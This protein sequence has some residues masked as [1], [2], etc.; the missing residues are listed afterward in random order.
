[1]P[2]VDAV[3]LRTCNDTVPSIALDDRANLAD[4]MQMLHSDAH[5]PLDLEA[6]PAAG[7]AYAILVRLRIPWRPGIRTLADRTLPAGLYT[8]CGSAHGP[9]GLRARV[10]RHLRPNKTVHWHVDRLTAAARIEGVA[11]SIG[12]SECDLVSAFMARGA[13]I[14]LPGFGSSDCRRCPAHLMMMPDDT[15]AAAFAAVV[16][17]GPSAGAP[18]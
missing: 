3:A 12:G 9:G 4:N 2:S 1:M 14:V 5:P 15:N 13:T 16:T 11:V 17:L 10:V 8:Y 7:G 6:I 18:L